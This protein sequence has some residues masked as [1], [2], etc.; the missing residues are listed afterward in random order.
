LRE[1]ALRGYLLPPTDKYMPPGPDGIAPDKNYYPQR[2][3]SHAS[4]K[5]RFKDLVAAHKEVIAVDAV[6]AVNAVEAAAEAEV[7]RPAAMS[8]E[9]AEVAAEAAKKD[10][11]ATLRADA[12]AAK[13][14]EDD[15]WNA[16][17]QAKANKAALRPKGMAKVRSMIQ[18][19]TKE[20][21][22]AE[23]NVNA[24]RNAWWAAKSNTKSKER[25][26]HRAADAEFTR[27]F[28]LDF[29]GGSGKKRFKTR[30]LRRG[31]RQ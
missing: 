13:V 10:W 24:A 22:E 15:A 27:N 17:E 20:M 2:A 3:A 30:K 29:G 26:A 9:E 21:K 6:E 5:K 23:A 16:V 1:I 12:D 25:M 19:K 14:K 18:G 28:G 11:I 4:R 8:R 31:Y 7:A